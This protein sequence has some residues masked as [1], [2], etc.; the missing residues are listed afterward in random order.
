MPLSTGKRKARSIGK[1]NTVLGRLLSIGACM[2][3]VDGYRANN[4]I[5]PVVCPLQACQVELSGEARL[6]VISNNAS[7]E[8]KMEAA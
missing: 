6:L 5:G 1:K 7:S 2:H 8:R 4:P 3:H